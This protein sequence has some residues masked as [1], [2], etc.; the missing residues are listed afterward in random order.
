MGSKNL[1][2]ICGITS[3]G[4]SD[5]TRP[6]PSRFR[7]Q[8]SGIVNCCPTSVYFDLNSTALQNCKLEV[9]DAA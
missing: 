7:S 3:F 8:M 2:E 9:R 4:M 5:L 1:A 6:D